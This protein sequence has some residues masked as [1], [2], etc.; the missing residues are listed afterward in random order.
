MS[1]INKIEL[2]EINH[3]DLE[4]IFLWFKDKE[5]SEN[6]G[7]SPESMDAQSR[8]YEGYCK[9]SSK[10]VY[11][12]IYEGIHIGNI[13]LLDINSD[14]M[15]AYLSIFIGDEKFRGRGLGYAA[16]EKLQILASEDFG[17]QKLKLEV[18]QKNI[19]AIKC[20]KKIGYS[21]SSEYGDK[22][23]MFKDII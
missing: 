23:L 9:D 1:I 4:R 2:R 7:A 3:N 22:I 14:E 10:V 11:A 6:I 16:L 13:S 18:L 5:V 8:W 19:R 12:I 20:Y 15:E 17:L 21:E